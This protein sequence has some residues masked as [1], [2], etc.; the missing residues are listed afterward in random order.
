[1]CAENEG[2]W[3]RGFHWVWHLNWVVKIVLG[4]TTHSR[5]RNSK[6]QTQKEQD[7]EEQ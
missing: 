7:I 4:G 2:S 3:T 6:R 1:M 5:R